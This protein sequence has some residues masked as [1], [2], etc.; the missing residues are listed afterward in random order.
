MIAEAP[1]AR[2]ARRI[3]DVVGS[4]D[5]LD[6]AGIVDPVTV[7]YKRDRSPL[8]AERPALT[9]IF[10]ADG[11]TEDETGHSISE[12]VRRAT[13]DLQADVVVPHND[14]TGIET[15]ERMLGAA[16]SALRAEGGPMLDLV[17]WIEAGDIDPE[18]RTAIEN[19]RMTI[20]LEIRYRVRQDDPFVMLAAGEN[21]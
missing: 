8:K 7:R 11:P 19:G 13:F 9:I 15:V 6:R 10:V 4:V 2:I 1:R 21:L 18:D 5:Y 3:G 20:S 14:V 12:L 16:V 17:D